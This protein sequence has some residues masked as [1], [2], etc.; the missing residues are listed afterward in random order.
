M[1]LHKIYKKV[2]YNSFKHVEF[3]V[4]QLKEKKWGTEWFSTE[5]LKIVFLHI[6][7]FLLKLKPNGKPIKKL[8]CIDICIKML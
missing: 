8:I 7:N 6:L 4:Q 5:D 2:S 3:Y 1:G